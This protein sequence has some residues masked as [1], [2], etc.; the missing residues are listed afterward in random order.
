MKEV[1]G[2]KKEGEGADQDPLNTRN[3]TNRI[4]TG[5]V[6]GDCV[7]DVRVDFGKKLSVSYEKSFVTH[8]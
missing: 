8:A 5:A 3:I 1:G 7:F 4:P 2:R 6:D